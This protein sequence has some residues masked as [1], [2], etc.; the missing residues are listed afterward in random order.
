MLALRSTAKSIAFVIIILALTSCTFHL[1]KDVA[2]E[3][4]PEELYGLYN[5]KHKNM[6]ARSKCP[7]PPSVNIIN[8]ET[9]DEDYMMWDRGVTKWYINPKELMNYTVNYMKDAFEKC[10][11]KVDVNSNKIINVSMNKANFTQGMWAQGA[12]I[13]LNIEIPEKRYIEIF[14]ATDNSAKS[15]MR[16]MAYA[17]HV[18]TWKVIADPVVYDYILC[19]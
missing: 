6:K 8:K 17:I 5:T 2:D 12:D 1:T 3:L 4:K 11:V 10:N 14:E 19:R 15:S 9:R 18:A 13:Q 7:M 16:A